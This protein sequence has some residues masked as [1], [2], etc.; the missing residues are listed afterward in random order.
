MK[1]ILTTA[2]ALTA[3]TAT[4]L[5]QG[6]PLTPPAGVPAPTMKTLDQVEPR[7]PLVAGSP[8]VSIGVSIFITQPGSYYL[9]G[10]LQITGN[11]TG[12]RINASGV[13]LDLM[14]HSII[15]PASGNAGS[16]IFVEADYSNIRI[17]NGHILS[18]TTFAE[19]S[20]TPN[21]FSYGILTSAGGI[22]NNISISNV[23]I[24]GSRFDGIWVNGQ[25]CIVANCSVF[26]T[27][28]IGIRNA[29]GTVVDS[30][31]HTT[32]STGISA[33]VVSNCR[34]NNALGAGI[35][36]A[37]VS[38]S[39]ARSIS[40]SGS[41]GIS[42]TTVD[43]SVGITSGIHGISATTVSNSR[44]QS[45]NTSSS[46]HGID[47]VQVSGSRGEASGGHGITAS[48]VSDSRGS[49]SGA[50]GESSSGI[51]AFRVSNSQ[52]TA[53]NAS[54]GRGISSI[55]SVTASYGTSSGPQ[56]I[57]SS[58]GTVS[59]SYGTS[60]GSTATSR[61]IQAQIVTNS[62]GVSTNTSG[63][64]GIRADTLAMNS[65]GQ[66]SGSSGLFANRAATNCYGTTSHTANTSHGISSFGTVTSSYGRSD[67]SGGGDG[68]NASIV[69]GSYGYAVS[70][71]RHGIDAFLAESSIG[72]R[73]NLGTS[74]FGLRA[75]RANFCR[76]YYGTSTPS[77]SIGTG[78]KYNM[79]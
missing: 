11:D 72:Q 18:T 58:E 60:S 55:Y 28:G 56:G 50:N 64:E 24:S 21:G 26:I 43:S 78:T 73:V 29:N 23:T 15:A 14:G 31:V 45:T 38:N 70:G 7:I 2:L 37:T 53:S 44:G 10:N 75:D 27:A 74:K 22:S 71:A 6:G 67:G 51:S 33:S 3:L 1:H 5:A 40:S 4:V 76:G 66:S 62:R 46:R 17:Q 69:K 61:G 65:Y 13:S 32:G 9:T 57:L 54:G 25:G 47:G 77:E 63:R 52:G 68:I 35:S 12:I 16:A 8:G 41:S 20:F 42:A 34:V 49:S 59:D 30:V 36:A 79:P 19:S 39:Y 48:S